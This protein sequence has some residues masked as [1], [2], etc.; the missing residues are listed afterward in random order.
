MRAPGPLALLGGLLLAACGAGEE[1]A[2]WIGYVEGDFRYLGP[3]DP[4]LVT[5]LNVDEGD[6]VEAG[7][8]L[9][10]VDAE[11]ARLAVAEAEAAAKAARARL[12]D[13]RRGGRPEEIDAARERLASAR[14]ELEL[15][16]EEHARAERLVAQG[17]APQRQLDQAQRSLNVAQARVEELALQLE[18]AQLPAREDA[19][20]AAEDEL[21][22]AEAR[23]AIARESL[24]DR[25]LKAPAEGRIQ[26]VF[27]R[28]G[29]FAAPGSPVVSLLPE[30]ATR[31]VFF[32]PQAALA[33]IAIGQ[34]V[35]VACDGCPDGLAAEIDF[36]APKTEYTPPVIFSEEERAKLVVQVE[37]APTD[38]GALMPGQ[39]VQIRPA[40]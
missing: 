3:R 37:A 4:G 35:A 24:N 5:T 38:P 32:V 18:L 34:R 6:R 29:E 40:P 13:L 2:H 33:D 7:A 22:A 21:A 15:A 36:I 11:R 1:E 17:A 23:A 26:R 19:V 39:P 28:P 16:Q 10:S 14:A 12:A 31:I 27:R 30:D 8:P 20:A 9:F 25:S